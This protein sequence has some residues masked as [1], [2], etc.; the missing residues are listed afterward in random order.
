M[1]QEFPKQA[2][3]VV[4]GGGIAGCST[5]Y[6]L[7]QSGCSDVVVL[8]RGKL[9]S[10]STWHAAGMVGQLRANSNITQLLRHSVELYGRLEEETGLA[11]GWRANGSL[12]LACTPERRIEFERQITMAKPFGLEASLLT[13]KEVADLC[14]GMSVDGVLC[15]AYVPSD[16]V[17]NPSDLTMSLARGARSFG[18]KIFEDSVVKGFKVEQGRVTGVVTDKGDIQCESVV[19]CAGIWSREIGRLA[20]VNIPIQP[21]HHQYMVSEKIEGLGSGMPSVRDPDNLTYFKEEVGGLAAGGYEFNPIPYL[22][23]PASDDAEFKLFPEA[24]DH[25]EQFLPQMMTRFPG[26]EKVGIKQWYNGLEAFTEDTNFILGEAPE[27]DGVFMACGFNAMGIAAGGGAGMAIAHWVLEGQPPVDLW[28]VDIRRFERY[29]KSD[30]NVLPRAVEGQGHHFAMHWPF[31]EFSAGRPLRRSPIYDRLKSQGACFGSRAGWERPNWFAPEGVE[32]KDEYSFYRQNWFPHV[33][34]EHKACR[35]AAVVFDQSSFSKAL[36]VGRDAEK[37]LQRICAADLSKPAGRLSYTQMLNEKGGIECDLTIARISEDTFYLVTGTAVGVHDFT[38]I[39]RNLHD[40]EAVSLVDVT[41]QY[42]VLGLM[43]PKA[44]NILS[45]ICEG[46]IS[47]EAFPFGHVRELMVAGAPVRAM[48]V[49]FVGELGWELHIPCEYMVTVYDALQSA[50]KDHGLRNAGYRAIDS[51]RQEKGFCVWGHEVG[52]DYTPL[53]AGVG[54]AV[55]FKKEAPFIGKDA[56]LSQRETGLTRKM[57]TFTVEDKEI[58]LL[59][60]EAIYRDG[61]SVGWLSSGGYAHTFDKPIGLGYVCN[62][63]GVTDDYLQS[64]SYELDVAGKRVQA[65]L[66]LRPIYDAES[67]RVKS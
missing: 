60:R 31:Y 56:L 34:A 21:A 57:A 66:H 52:P 17:A 58:V 35:E 29:N 50:G 16:G 6:H 44:R 54:F 63:D 61:E 7:G 42:G 22:S 24:I 30:R 27:V 4:I 40:D 53:E 32:P 46:D 55:S 67:K 5:A 2:R 19:I 45:V 3:V 11:T 18:V 10:G 51:L 20:G 47:N 39:K 23:A 41:S 49:T 36:I 8:E 28:P 37:A 15:G 26:L 14:P 43:G 13:P 25:F 48:R 62:S 64:G 33:A 12:R 9:T 65:Q 38:H 1:N 59:G